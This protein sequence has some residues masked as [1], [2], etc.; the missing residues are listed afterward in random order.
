MTYFAFN[1]TRTLM[2]P[3]FWFD[4]TTSLKIVEDEKARF[5]MR[6]RYNNLYMPGE[7]RVVRELKISPENA[8]RAAAHFV[9]RA[10]EYDIDCKPGKEAAVA[11]LGYIRHRNLDRL[12]KELPK[13]MRCCM[14]GEGDDCYHARRLISVINDLLALVENRDKILLAFPILNEEIFSRMEDV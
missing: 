2:E 12:Y 1:P 4:F 7:P 11:V 10:D 14:P 9:L 8:L 6:D 3:Y 5:I 13:G